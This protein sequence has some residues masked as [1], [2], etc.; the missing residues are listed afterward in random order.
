MKKK[1]YCEFKQYDFLASILDDDEIKILFP[2]EENENRTFGV[3]INDNLK[4]NHIPTV[5]IKKIIK[6]F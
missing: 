3:K 1:S 2:S 5:K 6:H 4:L